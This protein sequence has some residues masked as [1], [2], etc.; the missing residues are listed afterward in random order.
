MLDVIYKNKIQ[1]QKPEQD[2]IQVCIGLENA[3]KELHDLFNTPAEAR[4]EAVL[5]GN[6]ARWEQLAVQAAALPAETLAGVRARVRA[7]GR[8][9]V[10]DILRSADLTDEA[11]QVMIEALI[12]DLTGED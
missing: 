2:L 1:S 8:D 6:Q 4:A 10:A 12:R 9:F 5:A 3:N 11:E 7:L